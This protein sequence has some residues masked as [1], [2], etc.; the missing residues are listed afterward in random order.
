MSDIR[1]F[2]IYKSNRLEN[3]LPAV[4]PIIERLA[5]SAPLKKKSIIVQSDG[6]ARWLT[7]KTASESGAFANFEFV[8][9][10][11]FLRNFA[12]KHL[13]IKQDSVY[14]KKN[15]EWALYTLLRS[16]KDSPAASYIGN[17]DSRAFRFSRTLADLFTMI[18][19]VRP[20]WEK[21]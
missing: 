7:L 3:F 5:K 10:D 9:P 17:S 14:N 12:E 4:F 2:R 13:G 19:H 20:L 8:S 16:E 11:K 1:K 6:M 15:A 21:A 18:P